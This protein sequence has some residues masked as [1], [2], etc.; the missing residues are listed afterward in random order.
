MI[1]LEILILSSNT[2]LGG[3]KGYTNVATTRQRSYVRAFYCDTP[4]TGEY[5]ADSSR[6]AGRVLAGVFSVSRSRN[7][8]Y[9]LLFAG[10]FRAG[11]DNLSLSAD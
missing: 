6:F 8:R 5:S 7:G 11:S 3:K 1:T 9:S 10:S 2:S 4:G